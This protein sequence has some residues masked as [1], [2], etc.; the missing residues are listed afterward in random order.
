M[1]NSKINLWI[2]ETWFNIG[3][4]FMELRHQETKYFQRSMTCNPLKEIQ[5]FFMQRTKISSKHKHNLAVHLNA[6]QSQVV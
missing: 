2:T 6:P 1:N 5:A 4:A 3:S